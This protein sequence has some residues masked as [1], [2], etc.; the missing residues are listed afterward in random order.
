MGQTSRILLGFECQC[1]PVMRN[2]INVMV[3]FKPGEYYECSFSRLLS[4]Q[5]VRRVSNNFT[6]ICRHASRIR[7]DGV[8][9]CIVFYKSVTLFGSYV[10]FERRPV[11]SI[12][13]REGRRRRGGGGGGW[14]EG[15]VSKKWFATLTAPFVI[16]LQSRLN[17]SLRPHYLASD[18]CCETCEV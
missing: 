13:D 4:V 8:H 10:Q 11:Y 7:G 12:S 2:E 5:L 15:G 18:L 16:A 14:W 9:A 1:E 3:Y 6:S 17:Q